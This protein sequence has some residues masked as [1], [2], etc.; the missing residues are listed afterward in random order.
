MLGRQSKQSTT[1]DNP[2]ATARRVAY[3]HSRKLATQSMKQMTQTG[4][5]NYSE[6]NRQARN[7]LASITHP[8]MPSYRKNESA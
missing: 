2:S 3:D 7:A 1:T 8:V 5:N 4:Q 6:I